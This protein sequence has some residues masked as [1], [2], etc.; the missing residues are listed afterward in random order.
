[1]KKGLVIIFIFL[2]H[3]VSAS[4]IFG[5]EITYKYV[6]KATNG[7][8]TYAVKLTL[9]L[10][11]KD[12]R[13]ASIADDATAFINV[14]NAKTGSLIKSLCKEVGRQNPV[15]VS[16]NPYKCIKNSPD[17]CVDMYV[18]ETNMV[19]PKLANGY[20]ISF[21]RCCRN[22]VVVNINNP[23]N[24]GATY[25]TEIK[26]ESVIGKN[27]SPVFKARPPIFLCLNAPFVFDHSATDEDGDSLVYEICTPYLGASTGN[28]RPDF[29]SNNRLPTFPLSGNRLVSWKSPFN[30]NDEMG[31]NPL[32]EVDE[33][34]GRL[35]VTPDQANQFV[36]GIKV[37]EYRNGVLIGETRRDYQFNVANCVFEVVSVFYTAKTNCT[38]T[39]VTFTNQSIGALR[40]HWDFGE[41]G[42]NKDTSNI[43]SPTYIYAKA[44]TYKVMLI[45]INS[46]CIDTF[47]YLVTIKDNI[48]VRLGRDTIFCK[49]DSLKLNAGNAGSLFSWNTGQSTQSITVGQTGNYLVTVTSSPCVARDTILV[50]I[51]K[52]IFDAGKDTVQCNDN[53]IPFKYFVPNIYKS[54]LWSDNTTLDHMNIT[55]PGKYW[56]T[57]KNQ[58]NC[59]RT[60]TL[61]AFQFKPPKSYL[62]DTAV[63]IGA[64]GVFDVKILNY[65]Y[66]WNTGESS[67]QI[68]TNQPGPHW[69]T[70]TNGLCKSSD[71]AILSNIN[72]GLNLRNDTSFC[73]PF[74]FKIKTNKP[75]E[76]YEWSNG[77]YSR[78]T[79][80]TKP[81][82][83]KVAIKNADGCLQS[84]SFNIINYPENISSITGDTMACTSSVLDLMASS[85]LIYLW[86]TGETT[87]TIKTQ[88]GGIFRV[89][90]SDA[91]GCKDTVFHKITKNP[92]ALPNE[93]YMPNAFTPNG[94][95]LN[96][97]YPDNKFQDIHAFYNLKIFNRWGEKL[98]ETDSPNQSWD[99]LISGKQSQDDVYIYSLNYIG[100]DNQRHTI[101]GGF[102]LM[103]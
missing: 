87:Q 18:Y 11:C 26:P 88:E 94:D 28:G 2:A 68:S 14:F 59:Q 54:F 65:T 8:V 55:K 103:R 67:R 10:D 70:I 56:V 24:T 52:S 15:R 4:H 13:P 50:I 33:L 93:I 96:E 63:C 90:V 48:K 37:K 80:I 49:A 40:Y 30:V 51:D 23:G 44:G 98:F 1:M 5:G 76:T 73:G 25:W 100:C 95:K 69:V 101:N 29:N 46:V 7:D 42:T 91:N 57:I 47:D 64:S 45:A 36:M 31:G 35:T 16:A 41:P 6:S 17:V 43:K 3:W 86:S 78:E 75:F 32:L 19:L 84:D 12:G 82:Q 85:N 97:H 39:G 89:I 77:S 21:E 74:I 9:Y 53:F 20:I 81:G 66:L 92:N 79:I 71:T 72:P 61:E 58:N 102:N 83:V 62:R 99:G 34:T 38:N 27:S 60:D 22:T